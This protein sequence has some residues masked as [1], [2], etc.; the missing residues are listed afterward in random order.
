MDKTADEVVEALKQH[1][2]VITDSDLARALRLDK[3][4][5]SGWR[6]RQRVPAKFAGI[7]EGEALHREATAPAYWS[8]Y[9]NAAFALALFRYAKIFGAELQGNN[10]AEI[11]QI[12]DHSASDFWA[13]V[14]DAQY[15]TLKLGTINSAATT[16]ALL[17]HEDLQNPEAVV[18]K[19][20]RIMRE[21]RPPVD[22]A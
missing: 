17:I 20:D 22:G 10:F 21:N 15:D 5:V 19:C 14:R 18:E 16:L 9:E 12:L 11:I 3:R 1:F 2:K 13:I 7:L 6:A 4:T 8:D